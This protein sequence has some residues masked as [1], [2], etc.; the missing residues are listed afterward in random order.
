MKLNWF[1]GHQ[2]HIIA[3][4]TSQTLAVGKWQWSKV[5]NVSFGLHLHSHPKDAI[6]KINSAWI[7]GC[8]SFDSTIRGFGGCPF[9]KNELVGNIS[10]ESLIN[11]IQTKKIKH[12]INFLALETA[13]NNS[14]DIFK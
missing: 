11:Y 14:M 12:K 13:R 6:S 2:M 5:N 9:A 1:W 8:R 7:N 4:Q 3:C 10:T